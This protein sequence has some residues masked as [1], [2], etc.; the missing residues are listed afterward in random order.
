MASPSSSTVV[1]LQKLSTNAEFRD[2]V[3]KGVQYAAKLAISLLERSAGP[4][5]SAHVPT[6]Q[7]AAKSISSARRFITLLRWVKYIDGYKVAQAETDAGLRPLM[8]ADAYLSTIVDAL[9]DLVTLDKIGV[10]GK[11]GRLPVIVETVANNLDC[12]LAVNGM[13]LTGVKLVHARRVASCVCD[14]VCYPL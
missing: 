7:V 2:K 9:Q 1:L 11:P 8:F 4:G 6:L 14:S 3:L 13:A 5:R 10:F 12:L